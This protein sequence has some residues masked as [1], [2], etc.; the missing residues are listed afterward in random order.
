MPRDSLG[1]SFG[2]R[3]AT[4]LGL[5][6]LEDKLS[7]ALAHGAYDMSDCRTSEATA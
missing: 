5:R 7:A 3:A 4:G 2:A 6:Y 1:K